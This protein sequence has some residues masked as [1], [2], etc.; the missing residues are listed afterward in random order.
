M[1]NREAGLW[2]WCTVKLGVW[3]AAGTAL[4]ACD[5]QAA[6]PVSSPTG[7]SA[8][9]IA[10]ASAAAAPP[11]PAATSQPTSKPEVLSPGTDPS[12]TAAAKATDDALPA[13]I[14][15]PKSVAEAKE[16][17][18]F[19]MLLHGYTGSGRA[20]A[21]HLGL[22]ALAEAK[23]LV[24]AAPDGAKEKSGRRFW[25]TGPACCDFDRIG[26]DHVAALE[27]LL[28]RARATAL[29]DPDALYVVGYSNGGFMAHRLACELEGIA[30]IVSVSG[31]PPSDLGTCQ[32]TPSTVIQLH[33]NEDEIVRFG[34]GR[35]LDRTDVEPHP[36][37]VQGMV[38]W[39]K[40]AGCGTAPYS[41]G[42]LDLESEI[43]GDETERLR[44]PSCAN[45]MELWLVHGGRHAILGERRA[46]SAVIDQLLDQRP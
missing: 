42:K 46:F 13:S 33:G 10:P 17:R 7:P 43:D 39:A 36:G 29:V 27:K 25:N 11:Q 12:A 15:V 35:V 22:P 44:F 2:R 24:W 19:V 28:R 20:I 30:G 37:V 14:Q 32:A 23:R 34:G 6:P 8:S 9:A 38:A 4:G 18:P 21:S 31:L 41:L 26:V 45:R 1:G 5:G 40:R 3:L 16:K